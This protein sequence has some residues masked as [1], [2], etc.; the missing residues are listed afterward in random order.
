MQYINAVGFKY[1]G[2]VE[3]TVGVELI[4]DGNLTG[5]LPKPG[6]GLQPPPQTRQ[7]DRALMGSAINVH[8]A[9]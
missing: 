6:C 5:E 9:C 2:E 7:W 1:N 4:P 8:H 3:H